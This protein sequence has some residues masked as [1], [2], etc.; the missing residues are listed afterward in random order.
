M[1]CPT[2]DLYLQTTIPYV[3][4]HLAPAPGPL[5]RAGKILI[6]LLGLPQITWGLCFRTEYNFCR[7]HQTHLSIQFSLV[8]ALR[9]TKAH[10]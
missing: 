8:C 1:S 2:N 10:R 7:R 6:C 4:V 5:I 3:S 9:A